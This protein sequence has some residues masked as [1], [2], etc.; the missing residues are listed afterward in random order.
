M[1]MSLV[2]ARTFNQSPSKVKALAKEGPVF[3]TEHGRPTAVV[4]TIDDYERLRGVGNVR[5]SLRMDVDVDF[6][7]LVLR[8]LG[9]VADL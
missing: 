5:E 1:A 7:P 3:V 6:E 2:S 8:D 9:R 4:L